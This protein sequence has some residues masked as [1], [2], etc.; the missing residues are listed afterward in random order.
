[1]RILWITAAAVALSAHATAARADCA[2]P[3]GYAVREEP[4]GR[5]RICLENFAG[6]TCPDQGLLRTRVDLRCE[7]AGGAPADP[8]RCAEIKKLTSCDEAGCFVDECVPAGTYRYGLQEPYT[9]VHAACETSYYAEVTVTGAAAECVRTGPAPEDAATVPW[10][11]DPLVCDYGDSDRSG[12]S[13]GG[14][15]LAFDLAALVAGLGLWRL[16]A[17]RRPRA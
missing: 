16:R 1:M 5:V 8:A 9:C 10:S 15:V 11:N 17:R 2:M 6:R 14:S 3:V 12:C 4:A 13:T 7:P